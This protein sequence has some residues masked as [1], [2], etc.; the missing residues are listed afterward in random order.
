MTAP[1]KFTYL[2][3]S[4]KGSSVRMLRGDGPPTIMGG[5]GGWSV[6]SRPRRIGLTQWTGRDPYRMDVP[7]LFDGWANKVS[8]EVGISILNQMAMGYSYD[9][10]PTV[11]IDGAIPVKHATWVIESIEWGTDVIWDASPNGINSRLRQDAVVHLLQYQA[12]ERL[13]I[14]MPKSLPSTYTTHGKNT[15]MRQVSKAVYGNGSR[16]KDIM[17]ANPKIRDPNKIPDKTTLRIP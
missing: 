17:K 8:C 16:W 14:T 3:S 7:I 1:L 10:P 9:P 2:F 12:E 4:S 5:S 6:V 11:T 13:N 15:T